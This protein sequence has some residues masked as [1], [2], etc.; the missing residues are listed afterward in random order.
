MSKGQTMSRLKTIRNAQQQ[1]ANR[2]KEIQEQLKQ[3]EKMPSS[4]PWTTFKRVATVKELQSPHRS[5]KEALKHDLLALKSELRGMKIQERKV[6]RQNAVQASRDFKRRLEAALKKGEQ[7]G[8]LDEGEL[9]ALQIESLQVLSRFVDILNA[10]PSIKNVD[11]VLNEM[12]LPMLLG[13]DS[14]GGECDKAFKALG[15]ASVKL[16]NEAESKFR[17]NPTTDN[18]D[19][20]LQSRGLTQ[21]LGGNAEIKR[22]GWRSVGT[23]HPVVSGDTLSGISQ[24]YYGKPGYWDIIFLENYGVIGDDIKM[25]KQGTELKIP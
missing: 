3:V 17:T 14:P 6:I 9:A 13:A 21:K 20:F 22:E 19:S 5:L 15:N 18:L 16:Q 2:I 4:Q 23:T 24:K 1:V 12:E 25:L 11:T 10:N 8:A 7:S